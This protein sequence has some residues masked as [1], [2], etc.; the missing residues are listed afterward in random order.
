MFESNKNSIMNWHFNTS[1][2]NDD[3]ANF[4]ENS[5]CFEYLNEKSNVFV[6]NCKK[7]R[8]LIEIFIFNWMFVV[9]DWFRS[10]RQIEKII[11]FSTMTT[12]TIINNWYFK[13]VCYFENWYVKNNV[14]KMFY[15][16]S[17]RNRM[18]FDQNVW[19]VWNQL[20]TFL[21]FLHNIRINIE[22][23]KHNIKKL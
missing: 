17:I 2:L 9:D 4:N 23:I 1:S 13:I 15:C 20:L 5:K 6:E 21:I 16:L 3:N 14:E 10:T 12:T 7:K 19:N 18:H 22:F 8:K 11:K